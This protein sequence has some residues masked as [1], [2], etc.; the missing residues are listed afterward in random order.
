MIL[1]ILPFVPR[2]ASGNIV[3]VDP[4]YER[5]LSTIRP[6][7]RDKPGWQL[8]DPLPDFQRL[9]GHGVLPRG[10]QNTRPGSG[11]LNVVGHRAVAELLAEAIDRVGP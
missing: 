8:V 7:I 6:A 1:L 3:T 5:L 9:L 11:H 4:E 10:F 2:I